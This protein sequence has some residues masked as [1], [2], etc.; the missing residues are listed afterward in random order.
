MRLRKREELGTWRAV[1][2]SS[3]TSSGSTVTTAGQ[4]RPRQPSITSP[5]EKRLK[6]EEDFDVI[7][8][9]PTIPDQRTNPANPDHTGTSAE[10]K[11]EPH[12]QKLLQDFVSDTISAL[13]KEFRLINWQ[14]S[15]H[16]SRNHG[17]VYTSWT[18]KP[19]GSACDSMTFVLGCETVNGIDDGG[20]CIHYNLG[21]GNTNF[22]PGGIR[23]VLCLEV[24]FMCFSP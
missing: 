15:G 23:P 6:T 3:I 12:T 24:I 2:T 10:L 8:E 9:Q 16:K 20:L 19:D 21:E 4:K 1:R 17:D 18:M 5:V 13:R 22:Q 11:E 14:K 7:P